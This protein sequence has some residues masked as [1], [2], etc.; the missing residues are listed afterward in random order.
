M[1]RR[2]TRTSCV[3]LAAGIALHASQA[4]EAGRKA[5]VEPLAPHKLSVPIKSSGFQAVRADREG[6]ARLLTDDLRVFEITSDLGL[7]PVGRLIAEGNVGPA[8]QAALSSDGGSWLIP[9]P[10][11]EL[12]LF[13]GLDREG[14]A[15]TS[16][17]LP[18]HLV[19][20]A[21]SD[22]VVGAMLAE[23]F[24]RVLPEGQRHQPPL[25]WRFDGSEWQPFIRLPVAKGES[26]SDDS[27][28]I[29]SSALAASDRRDRLWVANEY[30]Y[31]VRRFSPS[32]R[33]E[34]VVK[35]PERADAAKVSDQRRDAFQKH[36]SEK[37]GGKVEITSAFT[38]PSP[39]IL[40]LTAWAGDAYALT[41][42]RGQ[43]SGCALDR[44]DGT[45]GEV[46]R[47]LIAVPQPERIRSL[48]ATKDG[49]LF[50]L[51]KTEQ[52]IYFADWAT[53]DAKW[54][55]VQSMP[56]QARSAAAGTGR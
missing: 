15:I 34:L 31:V 20:F 6:R 55:P 26:S 28:T 5:D 18:A 27:L 47:V 52:G 1:L 24:L 19:A 30:A 10:N 46:S 44:I 9:S 2:T 25:L 50:G 39:V 40:A 41:A 29:R 11:G 54:Y 53:L 36:I 51:A 21:G 48:A 4:Q 8:F 7:K 38:A 56:G 14:V 3:A 16:P 33:E 23:G 37:G 22:P 35:D 32:G 17:P 13:D 45:T 42:V 43:D 12:L 49:L